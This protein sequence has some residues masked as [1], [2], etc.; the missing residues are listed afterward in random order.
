MTS[1]VVVVASAFSS[2]LVVLMLAQN[3]TAINRPTMPTGRWVSTNVRK[4]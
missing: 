2:A 1:T 3:I 4:M